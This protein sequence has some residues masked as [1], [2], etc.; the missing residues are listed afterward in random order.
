MRLWGVVATGG[1]P[2]VMA[3]AQAGRWYALCTIH[4]Y[5]K[6]CLK[7]LSLHDAFRCILNYKLALQ[8][9]QVD[10][11]KILL[12]VHLTSGSSPWAGPHTG[13]VIGCI[14]PIL[15][16]SSNQKLAGSGSHMA[17]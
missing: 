10:C 1:A 5:F 17:A 4:Q 12:M 6:R 9:F 8:P 3:G 2:W 15:L 16:G 14:L 11:N 7:T 13:L